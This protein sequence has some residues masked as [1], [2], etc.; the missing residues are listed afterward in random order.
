MQKSFSFDVKSL[1]PILLSFIGFKKSLSP[2]P[3]KTGFVA[4]FLQQMA[5]K[6]KNFLFL[7]C[8]IL[9]RNKNLLQKENTVKKKTIYL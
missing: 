9:F 5:K 6:R 7:R 3:G 2:I 4:G 8:Y 1:I